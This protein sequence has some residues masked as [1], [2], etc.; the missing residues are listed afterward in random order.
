MAYF[1]LHHPCPPRA[2]GLTTWC[3]GCCAARPPIE[4]TQIKVCDSILQNMELVL[5]RFQ[6]DLGKVSEEIR[7]LQVQRPCGGRATPEGRGAHFLCA[8]TPTNAVHRNMRMQ[9]ALWSWRCPWRSMAWR[10]T[11]VLALF[12]FAFKPSVNPARSRRQTPFKP[13]GAEPEH[14]HEAEEPARSRVAAGLLY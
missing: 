5:G 11:A 9:S 3:C 1:V 2:V 4:R 6:S 12:A 10:P 13:A 7:H 14:G 8:Q